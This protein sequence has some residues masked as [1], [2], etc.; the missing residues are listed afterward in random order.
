MR[1]KHFIIKELGVTAEYTRPIGM[2]EMY[3]FRQMATPEELKQ[4]K[5]LIATDQ[6]AAWR[7]LEKVTKTRLSTKDNEPVNEIAMS[8]SRLKQM[9]SQ[10]DATCGIE[11][12]MIVPAEDTEETEYD[13]EYDRRAKTIIDVLQFYG[14]FNSRGDIEDAKEKIT[15]AYMSWVN[16]QISN[17]FSDKKI[18]I[19]KEYLLEEELDF[20][21][22]L[23]QNLED[24]NLSRQEIKL[25]L[26][27]G[28]K[29][30]DYSEN[31]I[32]RELQDLFK[33]KRKALENY[34][35][36]KHKVD[37]F[38]EKLADTAIKEKNELYNT[39]LNSH[40]ENSIDNYSERDFFEENNLYSMSD[41]MGYGLTWP[42]YQESSKTNSIK[43]ISKQFQE[44][45]NKPVLYGTDYKSVE[46]DD[47]S[48]IVEPDGSIDPMGEEAMGLEFISPPM[49]LTEMIN[50][51]NKV[52]SWAKSI[53]A[54]TNKT[55]G[56]HMNVS[57]SNYSRQNCDYIKLALLLGDEYVLSQFQRETNKYAKSSLNIIR[58]NILDYQ[59]S[60]M[61][62]INDLLLQMKSNLVNDLKQRLTTYVQAEM[63]RYVSINMKRNYIEFR[64]PG[65]DWLDQDISTLENTLLRFV[66]ALDAS[67]DPMKYRQ[68]YLKKLYLLLKPQ[69]EN[70][71]ISLFIKFNNKQLNLQEL[72]NFIQ[73]VIR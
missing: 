69:S 51:L 33:D 26:D 37:Q 21:E 58:K 17:E 10:V 40:F 70:D 50:D 49:S 60:D 41:F 29:Y 7:L 63:S 19:I 61:N 45:I 25:A 47:V 43:E 6:E 27:I 38:V 59:I 20:Y 42:Y 44:A 1:A 31:E 4:M 57:V 18:D 68:E 54:Y 73:N 52:V 72:K 67:C 2:M 22:L 56:L 30:K 15:E 36:A 66:V 28:R 62:L 64:S 12:E 14:D 13:F 3:K 65:G 53:G 5:L 8:P 71:I 34:Q 16:E 23:E 39:A 55:T 48:Y 32:E 35:K 24:M 46:R 11:F 9:A